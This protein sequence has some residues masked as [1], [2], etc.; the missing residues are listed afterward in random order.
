M[1]SIFF[2]F[3][4]ALLAHFDPVAVTQAIFLLLLLRSRE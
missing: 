4:F 1:S 2:V 3:G